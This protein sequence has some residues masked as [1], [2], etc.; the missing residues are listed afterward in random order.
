[1]S[2]P[3]GVDYSAVAKL[4]QTDESYGTSLF[5][6]VTAVLRDNGMPEGL[7]DLH[8]TSIRKE[9]EDILRIK[10][11]PQEAMDQ[12]MCAAVIAHTNAF[13]DD[14]PSFIDVCNVLSGTPASPQVFDPADIYEIAWG[15]TEAYI[16]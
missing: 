12:L 14:L 11:V 4:L 9:L 16:I 3:S 6:G 15:L 8:P 7:Y 10:H 2:D 5:L 1:M 13:F